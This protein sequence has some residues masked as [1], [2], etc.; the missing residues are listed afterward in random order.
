MSFAVKLREVQDLADDLLAD[1]GLVAWSFA[2]NRRKTQMGICLETSKSIQLSAYFV[3][4][5]GDEAILDTLLHEIA[6]A[7]VGTRHGHDAVWQAKCIELGAKPER[8]CNDAAM[9]AGRWQA[10]CQGCGMTHH[11]HRKPKHRIGWYC[12]HCGRVRGQLTWQPAGSPLV[13]PALDNVLPAG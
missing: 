5:N 7:L 13:F 4:L 11:R 9:P 10:L 1:H 8:V 2:F 12:R 6:H 3:L